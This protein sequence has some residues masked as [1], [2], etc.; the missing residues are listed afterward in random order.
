MED[1]ALKNDD[2]RR[3]SII[4]VSSEDDSLLG[5][6]PGFALDDTSSVG[7]EQRSVELFESI[8]DN[9]LEEFFEPVDA[10]KLGNFDDILEKK[11]LVPQ[12]SDCVE[13]EPGRIRKNGKYNLRKSLA[14]DTAFFTSDGVLDSEELSSMI[15][16]DKGQKQMLPGI[17]EEVH[18]STDSISTLE[19]EALTLESVEADLFEDIR[20]S[21]QKSSKAIKM[22]E[23]NSK[24]GSGVR[25]TKVG[26]ASKRVDVT[27]QQKMKPKVAPK[28][29]N[30]SMQNPGKLARPVSA[31]PQFS[32]SVAASGESNLSLVKRPKVKD[33][34]IPS[35]ETVAKRASLGGNV[36]KM[37]KDKTK[38]STGRGA[39]VSKLPGSLRNVPR[40][41][42]S[43]K[44]SSVAYST[45]TT[46]GATFSFDS[47]GS[48]SS[49]KFGKSPSN[50]IKRKTDART[51]NPNTSRINP[52][53]PSGVASRNKNDSGK[54]H[55]PAQLMPLT[56]L[57]SSISPASS[58]S[59]RSSESVSSISNFQPISYSSRDSI[60]KS[61]CKRVS[62][63]FDAAQYVDY[64]NHTDDQSSVGSA[65][66]VSG[67]PGQY[68][69]KASTDMA[70]VPPTS[71]PSGLR[72]PSPKIGFFDG[73][74]S[75]VR[76]PKRS[77]QSHPAVPSNL[78][79]I[80]A[81]SASP[82][83]S[84]VKGKLG[85]VTPDRAVTIGTKPN[86]Q[87]TSSNMKPKI[88]TLPE[89]LKAAAEIC[90]V[91]SNVE[92]HQVISPKTK[93]DMLLE[94]GN[95]NYVKADKVEGGG[96]DVGLHDKDPDFVENS[97]TIVVLKAEAASE[98]KCS[99]Q[100]DV[101]ITSNSE[102]LTATSELSFIY[103]FENLILSQEVV[104]ARHGELESNNDLHF[105][106]KSNE[107]ERSHSEENPVACL[108]R[109]VKAMEIKGTEE[110]VLSDDSLS[111]QHKLSSEDI[112]VSNLSVSPTTTYE[113]TS[114]KRIPFSAKDSL[115]NI[116]GLI[117][118]SKGSSVA[119]AAEKNSQL[120][121]FSGEQIE[122]EQLR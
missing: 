74:K 64:Q 49:V 51:C 30:I 16:V 105:P 22:A 43:S 116:G 93:I 65:T 71:K 28:K 81:A 32:Q 24:V 111:S 117:D 25:E 78:P 91:L 75:A 107:K 113:N 54:S 41:N 58:I 44:C 98:N 38:F 37:E 31:C 102:G 88:S 68:G 114:C 73:V 82:R 62:I 119:E 60:N 14:W 5:L 34:P 10:N 106:K 57:S 110:A 84:A 46:T 17:Q 55:F 76:T 15:A 86:A 52:K 87:R 11:E 104:D 1:L 18:R 45:A 83:G 26:S 121:S 99:A 120:S 95:E 35:A 72:L 80:A 59:D 42:L 13:P 90:T 6:A 112:N 19:S 108:T 36:L 100:E 23:E 103:N 56:K 70:S 8:D 48:T 122:T 2:A 61:F 12:P 85:K 40:P 109:Q 33:K 67:L 92:S 79:K 66:D 3:L 4:D 9:K 69:L 39:P 89:A 97:G 29:P 118:L 115:C 94:I 50:S 96:D 63:D 27:S 53:T 20:A 47:S 77:M 7:Q 21:I 101:K